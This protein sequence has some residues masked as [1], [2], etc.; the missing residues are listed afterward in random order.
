[1]AHAIQ[2][3][4]HGGPEVLR[5]EEVPVP[6]RGPG[7]AR[8]R[9]RAVGVNFIDVY[10]RTGRE[11]DPLRPARD[12]RDRRQRDARKVVGGPIHMRQR[13]RDPGGVSRGDLR[14][15]PAWAD[16]NGG[17]AGSG[18]GLA[19]MKRIVETHG[20]QVFHRSYQQPRHGEACRRP[21]APERRTR[22][23]SR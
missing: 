21:E 1:M 19:I 23:N 7:E 10:Q 12:R 13:R 5:W 18:M 22:A 6:D 3:H 16:G 11:R 15:V 4:Q 2:I 20:G 14:D 8:I 9:Q 17:T